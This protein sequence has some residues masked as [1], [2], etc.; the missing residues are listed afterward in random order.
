MKRVL[1][2]SVALSAIVSFYGIEFTQAAS[3]L[4]TTYNVLPD[5]ST[6]SIRPD[7][8]WH[9]VCPGG[10]PECHNEYYVHLNITPC[11]IGETCPTGTYYRGW[12]F[13]F[14]FAFVD[15]LIFD[16][17]TV[18]RIEGYWAETNSIIQLM[19][20]CVLYCAENDTFSDYIWNPI[21]E[22]SPVSDDASFPAVLASR[23]NA[24][25]PFNPVTV[26]YY[27]VPIGM[28][29]VRLS[30]YDMRGRNVRTLVNM[31]TAGGRYEVEWNG[32]DMHGRESPSGVYLSRLSAGDKVA[33]GRM[34]LIR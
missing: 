7:D 1:L 16:N 15:V 6:V 9:W 8:N 29:N 4:V 5:Q 13:P 21:H 12:L 33:Y 27:D 26:I 28:G 34:I 2:L 17:Y 10:D 14:P 18:Y 11:P 20:P 30:I 32:R 25:N 22:L 23:G 24:P 3:L 19:P 31:P